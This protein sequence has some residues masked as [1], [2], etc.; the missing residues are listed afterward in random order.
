MKKVGRY[1]THI[2]YVKMVDGQWVSINQV[3]SVIEPGDRIVIK[4]VTQS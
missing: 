4:E 1:I 2:I 3:T